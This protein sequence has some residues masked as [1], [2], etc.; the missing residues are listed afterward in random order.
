MDLMIEAKDKEQAVF[1]LMRTF[2]LPGFDTF[3]DVIPY[4]RNDDNKVAVMAANKK[5]RSKK[6]VYEEEPA[7]APLIDDEA[8]GMG[9]PEGR[10]Y[11]P[12]GMEEWL[13]P[14]KREVKKKD[15]AKV[16]AS[17]AAKAVPNGVDESVVE[18]TPIT[19]GKATKIN[20]KRSAPKKRAAPPSLVSDESSEVSLEDDDEED[21]VKPLPIKR[22]PAKARTTGRKA[23]KSVN[24]N[25]EDHEMEEV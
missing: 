17:P 12:P 23:R 3:N 13:R 6:V 24:Y 25:E 10:V 20:G 11:W 18:P 22:A 14:K 8:V 19:N 16:T 4:V 1:E 5:A 7:A 2:K 21:A 15:V 9:G